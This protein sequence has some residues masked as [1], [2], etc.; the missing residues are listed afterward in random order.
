[1]PATTSSL[2]RFTRASMLAATGHADPIARGFEILAA[3]A[4]PH[5]TRWSVVYDLRAR[6]AH[7]RTDVNGTVRRLTLDDFDLSCATPVRML[8]MN[9]A[10]GGDVGAAF[11]DYTAAA[12]RALIE[13]AFT[14][15]PF[16]QG[17]PATVKD[18]LAKHPDTTSSC[19]GRSS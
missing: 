16:L 2:D 10:G 11:V 7:F 15:T 14:Q 8:D 9:A 12:N 17:V 19:A 4:Q 1:M 5:F 18:A 13:A 3:V 6:V